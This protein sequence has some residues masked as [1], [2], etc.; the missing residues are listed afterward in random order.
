[1]VSKTARTESLAQDL[2]KRF[3]LHTQIQSLW[4][5]AIRAHLAL[6]RKDPATGITTL[7]ATSPVELG[8]IAFVHNLSC[9]Y[10]VYVRGERYLAAGQ[11]AA[12]A[13]EFQKIIDYNG[14]V[15]NCW[16]GARRI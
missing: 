5:P 7:Q 11:G 4:L 13:A 9:L 1:M 10:L 8:Q 6:D 14:I 2:A 3:P 16:T 12:A 15:W